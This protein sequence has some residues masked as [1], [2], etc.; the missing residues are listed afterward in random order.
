[1]RVICMAVRAHGDALLFP[2]M[3]MQADYGAAGKQLAFAPSMQ[4]QGKL[5][6]TVK[7]N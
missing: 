5:W 7:L 2:C 1:M 6:K 3:A 4:P